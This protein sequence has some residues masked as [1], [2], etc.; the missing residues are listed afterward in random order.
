MPLKTY[1]RYDTVNQ[2]IEIEPLEAYTQNQSY[3]LTISKNVKSKGGKNL[4]APVTLQFK[5]QD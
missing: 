2:Y 4:K 3:I 5:I 1:I